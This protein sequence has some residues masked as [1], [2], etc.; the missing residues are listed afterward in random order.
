[1]NFFFPAMMG[2]MR[3]KFTLPLFL[4][5]LTALPLSAQDNPTRGKI[6]YEKKCTTCHGAEAMGIKSQEAPRLRGQ[7]DWYL[8]SSLKKFVSGERKN[9]K[10]LPYLKGL[11]EQDFED[12]AAYLSALK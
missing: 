1:M 5:L 4:C 11:T 10:M 6:L 2:G 8:V 7:Y 12:I 3:T 9:P